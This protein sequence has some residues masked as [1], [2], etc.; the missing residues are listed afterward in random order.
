MPFLVAIAGLALAFG[1]LAV[2][3][4]E[5]IAVGGGLER[6]ADER[7]ELAVV[8]TPKGT[9]SG[10]VARQATSTVESG[11]RADPSVAAVEALEAGEGGD[12]IL[13]VTVE[14][15]TAAAGQSAAERVAARIDPGPYDATVGG[16]PM[17][18]AAA[19]DD[20][21]DELPGLALL[22]APLALL[23][24][25]LSFGPR[26]MAAPLLA[27][28]GAALGAVALLRLLPAALDLTAAGLAVAVAV[29]LA[30]ATEACH[31]VGRAHDE[32][33]FAAPEAMLEETLRAALPRIGCACAGAA[34]A[35]AFLLA[36]P[37]PAARSA[38]LGGIAAALLAAALAPVA[39]A[40][41]IALGPA[42]PVA[43]PVDAAPGR[44]RLLAGMP[45]HPALAWIPAVAVVGALGLAISQA[46]GTG[47]VALAAGDLGADAGPARV[48]AILAGELPA[49]E[50][51]RLASGSERAASG[52]AELV[53]ERLP[54]LLGAI[55]LAGLAAAY[56]AARSW[57]TA[58]AEGVGSALPAGAACG[59]V[60]LLGGDS[61]PV[62]LGPFAAGPHASV[63]IALLAALGAI[64]VARAAIVDRT[65]ALT[66]TIVAGAA[67][68]VLAGAELDALAQL[69]VALAAGL[70]IDL[71]LVR[72]VLAPCLERALPARL[73]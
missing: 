29:G 36:I 15:A 25:G 2:G 31:A 40:S 34:G 14:A 28:T 71:V 73:A 27:S 1:A 3:A 55:T 57:R 33:T 11:L 39:M 20:L 16:E 42:R 67:V 45:D 62:E 51:E 35:A 60:A 53:R 37:L 6:E 68:G 23:A 7:T 48:A 30:V 56:G 63:L 24:L 54:W 69:G 49:A 8:L 58:L 19:R 66:G 38:A 52:A 41:V 12:P 44:A 46:I 70:A 65:A 18:Q 26:R 17:V 32:V 5:R 64:G 72:A 4:A 13:V 50:A 59:L 22:A 47:A 10:A 21:E 43:D 61:A 9:L